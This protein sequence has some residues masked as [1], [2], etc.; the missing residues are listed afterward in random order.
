MVTAQ[1]SL[2][3]LASNNTN[4]SRCSRPITLIFN[5]AK[6]ASEIA[7]TDS[8]YVALREHVK[9]YGSGNLTDSFVML[10]LELLTGRQTFEMLILF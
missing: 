10:L 7:I 1:L 3:P 8:G 4:F 5:V 9:Q 6:Q 2:K